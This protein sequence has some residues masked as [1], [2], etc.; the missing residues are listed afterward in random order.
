MPYIKVIELLM[1]EEYITVITVFS[2]LQST[3][4]RCQNTFVDAKFTWTY[5]IKVTLKVLY[6][7]YKVMLEITEKCKSAL[8]IL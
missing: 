7:L 8:N 5:F 4:V 6:Y 3:V 2:K 1:R